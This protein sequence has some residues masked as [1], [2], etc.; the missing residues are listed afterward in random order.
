MIL[1]R[2]D[3]PEE[4][5]G[6]SLKSPRPSVLRRIHF[7]EEIQAETEVRIP[8]F[9]DAPIEETD[10][11][12]LRCHVFQEKDDS[13]YRSAFETFAFRFVTNTGNS[14]VPISML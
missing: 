8:L 9:F 7:P 11:T 2:I 13:R 4:K 3:F 10:K 1:R 14:D 12:I 6:S 5:I